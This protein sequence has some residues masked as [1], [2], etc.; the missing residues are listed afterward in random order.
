MLHFPFCLVPIF[1]LALLPESASAGMVRSGTGFLIGQGGY[2]ITNQ[3]VVA[4]CREVLIRGTL[5]SKAKV[6]AEDHRYD[7]ALL[8][9]EHAGKYTASLRYH[10]TTRLEKGEPVLVMGYPGESAKTGKYQIAQSEVI[11]LRGPEDEKHW[12]QFADSA[13]KGN[14][15]GPLLDSSGHVAGVVVA[16]F[17][18]WWALP[19][20]QTETQKTDIAI[21]LPILRRFLDIHGVPYRLSGS[22]LPA[23]PD[24]IEKQAQ[25]YIVNVICPQRP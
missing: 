19:G 12:I 20:N 16:S 11:D 25:N 2:I 5:Q 13:Q 3:H 6:I 22:Y 10:N 4:G 1:V 15:G 21:S 14:S 24:L 17:S 23:A 18:R 8:R 9:S 7:L